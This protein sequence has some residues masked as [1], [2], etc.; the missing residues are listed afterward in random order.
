[1]QGTAPPP[2]AVLPGILGPLWEAPCTAS[3]GENQMPCKEEKGRGEET[4]EHHPEWQFWSQGL[5]D[6]IVLKAQWVVLDT[7]PLL[8]RLKGGEAEAAGRGN[9]F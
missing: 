1:M 2:P 4:T 7:A 9:P 8:H 3:P 5:S 6:G